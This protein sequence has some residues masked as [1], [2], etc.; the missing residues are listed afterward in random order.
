MA[1]AFR[2]GRR[3]WRADTTLQIQ[4]EMRVACRPLCCLSTA[5]FGMHQFARQSH[6]RAGPSA[7]MRRPPL[8]SGCPALLGFVAVA[9]LAPLPLVVI[10]KHAATSQSTKRAARA[11]TN[12]AMLGAADARWALPGCGFVE[13]SA[14]YAG[15]LRTSCLSGRRWDRCGLTIGRGGEER[16]FGLGERSELREHTCRCMFERSEQSERSEFSGRAQSEHRSGVA[17]KRRPPRREPT[18]GTA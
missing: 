15:A 12:P 9:E 13:P 14:H 11:A 8:R 5:G 2:A 6:S 18:A 16:S 17:A 3:R 4:L 7:Q 1:T 10:L